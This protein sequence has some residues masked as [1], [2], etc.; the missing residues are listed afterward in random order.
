LEIGK[1]GKKQHSQ[2]IGNW[3]I[4]KKQHSHW[5]A[6]FKTLAAISG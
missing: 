1:I 5:Q 6:T 2:V 3:I 4:G